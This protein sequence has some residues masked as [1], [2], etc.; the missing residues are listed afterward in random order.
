[1]HMKRHIAIVILLLCSFPFVAQSSM[2]IHYRS[3]TEQ[4]V[5]MKV[6]GSLC[7]LNDSIPVDNVHV[8]SSEDGKMKFYSWEIASDGVCQN[9]AVIC[10]YLNEGG[11]IL[12]EDFR[13]REEEPG[14]VSQVHSIKKSDG[15][16]YYIT[17]RKQRVSSN[18][19]FMWMDGFMI[20][21]DTLRDVSVID[22][23]DD[24][25]ECMLEINH[26]IDG[27][28][29]ATDGEGWDWL[30]EY[31][32]ETMDLYV[33]NA[34]FIDDSIPSFNDRYRLYHFDGIEFVCQGDVPHKRLHA[35][36]HCYK[37]LIKF[38]RTK[39]YIVRIDKLETGTYRYASWKSTA[40]M[41]EK[42]VLV[43]GGGMYDAKNNSYTFIDGGNEY[44]VG[45]CEDKPISKGFLGHYEYLLVQKNGKTLLKE[46]KISNTD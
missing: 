2:R 41:S 3:G 22:G 14:W 37:R 4:D 39:N 6:V 5:P 35:S 43:I 15:I 40:N 13:V 27:W 11:K 19:G 32:T 33:P 30:F 17:T 42:P 23:G 25:D 36:L 34:I 10:Q 1:M 28:N 21:G 44:K 29:L 38:F 7:F 45:Y 46:E 12:T 31:D 26:R 24:L 16:T 18:E 8:C 20:D 9:Y